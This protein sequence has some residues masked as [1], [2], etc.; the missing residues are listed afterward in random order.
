[1]ILTLYSNPPTLCKSLSIKPVF[2]WTT[3]IGIN[4]I[5]VA[6]ANFERGT[7]KMGDAMLMNQLGSSGVTLRNKR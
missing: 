4:P 7:F 6:S 3:F 5:K 2:T 1:M